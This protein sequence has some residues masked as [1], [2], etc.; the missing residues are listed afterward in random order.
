LASTKRKTTTTTTKTTT[1]L[2]RK[3]MLKYF[4]VQFLKHKIQNGKRIKSRK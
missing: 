4:N 2:R 1:T 3:N